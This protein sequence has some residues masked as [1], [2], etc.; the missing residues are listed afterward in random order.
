M[1][2]GNSTQRTERRAKRSWLLLVTLLLGLQLTIGGIAIALA[3]SDP[4]A[5]VVPNYHRA[6]LDW[7]EEQASRRLLGKLGWTLEVH[8]SETPNEDGDR[9][10][11]ARLRNEMDEPVDGIRIRVS[12]FHLARGNDVLEVALQSIGQGRY[13]ALVPI[14]NA[15]QWQLDFELGLDDQV[16]RVK[17]NM[18]VQ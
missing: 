4:S 7:D 8:V 15:G 6:A 9:W 12:A 5:A 17:Q 14:V 11:R 3:T 10:L 1:K 16:A 13:Q 2:D 18:E